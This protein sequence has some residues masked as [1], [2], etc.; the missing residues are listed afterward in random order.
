MYVCFDDL[1]SNISELRNLSE[2]WS[3]KH[4]A[5][6]N[7]ETDAGDY[8]AMAIARK[9]WCKAKG[10]NSNLP[11]QPGSNSLIKKPEVPQS[12]KTHRHCIICISFC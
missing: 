11:R 3:K 4:S 7:K 5:Q 8:L 1:T 12:D 2:A 10:I 9:F 6:W